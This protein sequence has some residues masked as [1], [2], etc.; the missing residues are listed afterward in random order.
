[1]TA[2]ARY[3]CLS[4]LGCDRLLNGEL[5]DELAARA[6]IASC[7]ECEARLAEHVGEREAFAV[8]LP[9]AAVARLRR[10]A[11]PLAPMTM[12]AALAAV[13]V[14]VFVLRPRPDAVTREKG[15]P[16]IGFYVAHGGAVRSGAAGEIVAPGDSIEFTAST[17]RAGWLAIVSIDAAKKTSVYYPDA[18]AAAPIAPGRDQVLPLSVI[19][20]EVVGREW[21]YGVFCDEPFGVD[22]A[23]SIAID[24]APLPAGCIVDSLNI[25]KSPIR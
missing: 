5:P 20:D 14:G 6:H 11:T 13:V 4:R 8:P 1:M 17:E 3:P 9:R 16:T 12:I 2:A 18:L 7:R 10:P 21:I 24:G 23:K 22:R 25:E 15:R 19:L